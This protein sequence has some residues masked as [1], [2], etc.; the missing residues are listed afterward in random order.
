MSDVF[1]S[2]SRLD[3][4]FVGQ[5]REALAGQDQEVWIDWES[6]SALAGVVERNSE[7]HCEGE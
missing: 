2:Y 3:K 5:L 4:E 6:I 1:I 7:G